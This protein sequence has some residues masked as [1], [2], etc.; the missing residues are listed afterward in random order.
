M[1]YKPWLLEL[2]QETQVEGVRAK[3]LGLTRVIERIV[4]VDGKY[5][6]NRTK[7]Q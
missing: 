6:S 5:S 2:L 3:V 7:P 1:K 4:S